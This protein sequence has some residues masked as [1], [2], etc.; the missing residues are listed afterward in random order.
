MFY[1]IYLDHIA[2]AL[3]I[4]QVLSLATQGEITA[5]DFAAELPEITAG[6]KL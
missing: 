6:K 1:K 2:H 5:T 4:G 3:H